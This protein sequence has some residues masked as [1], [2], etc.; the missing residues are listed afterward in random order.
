MIDKIMEMK[1][2]VSLIKD[3][4]TVA[5]GTFTL[6]R[7]PMALLYEIVRNGLKD[8]SLVAINC[9]PT[10]DLLVGAGC[11]REVHAPYIGF[12]YFGLAPNVRRSVEEG[13]VK[14]VEHTE[15][16]ILGGLQATNAKVPFMPNTSLWG[17]DLLKVRGDIKIIDSPY[18]NEKVI[19]VP[20]IEP[21]VAIVHVHKA[22]SA[23]NSQ[24][25]STPSSDLELAL[26]SKKVIITTEEIVPQEFIERNPQ[27]TLITEVAVDAVVY[28]PYG[29]HPY[30]CYPYYTLDH[31]HVLEYL[32]AAN[33]KDE[34]QKYL[35]KYVYP[36]DH[37]GYLELVGLG[38]LLKLKCI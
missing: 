12:E 6:M 25:F 33:N 16:T 8:L 32:K 22:D 19:A 2:A 37:E 28:A 35:Q 23:G 4:D 3:G 31:E 10:F 14:W 21:D 26:A 30:Y 1:E 11:A 24:V 17:S 5:T 18:G 13:A 34:F 29:A 38:K 20:P 7:P 27:A 9:G 15:L 36:V